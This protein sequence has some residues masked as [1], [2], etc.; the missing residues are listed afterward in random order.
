MCFVYVFRAK[1]KSREAKVI[2]TGAF[3]LRPWLKKVYMWDMREWVCEEQ[4]SP[5][6]WGCFGV[7]EGKWT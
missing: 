4:A 1:L 7:W 2:L 6:I 3:G 5:S